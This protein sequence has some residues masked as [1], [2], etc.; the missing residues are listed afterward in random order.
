M[1]VGGVPVFQSEFRGAT[2]TGTPP[3][4]DRKP[5]AIGQPPVLTRKLCRQQR[6]TEYQNQVIYPM[7]QLDNNDHASKQHRY[8]R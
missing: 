5:R 2:K 3:M 8:P 4:A 6:N 7:R 1:A